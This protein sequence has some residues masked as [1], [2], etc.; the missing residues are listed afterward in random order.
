MSAKL[1]YTIGILLT[2]AGSLSQAQGPPRSCSMDRRSQ[3]TSHAPYSM[4]AITSTSNFIIIN[5]TM[6]PPY[7][8]P[9]WTNPAQACQFMTTYRIP[10]VP[11]EAGVPI[12]LAEKLEVY[13]NITYLKEN[14]KPLLG[15]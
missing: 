2:A 13:G 8:N 9:H 11:K 1:V 15:K 10:L 5:T 6:C 4:P 7:D 3:C 14:P 12:P